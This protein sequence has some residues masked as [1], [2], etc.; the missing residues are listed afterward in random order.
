[1]TELEQSPVVRTGQ[2]EGPL[3]RAEIGARFRA[4]FADRAFAGTSA[5]LEE[6]LEI[7]WDGHNNARKSPITRRAGAEF[8]DPDY[9]LS[10]DWLEARGAIHS[11]QQRYQHESGPSR[12]LLICG[13]AR[14]DKTCPGEMSKSYRMVQLAASIF[15]Q[16]NAEVDLR[17]GIEAR[18][19]NLQA[20]RPK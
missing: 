11:A 2:G 3:S 7:A 1:M 5:A 8:A 18:G 9:N 15:E 6:L 10:V 13:A 12:V 19:A 16:Q 14:N 4:R 20:P 17:T